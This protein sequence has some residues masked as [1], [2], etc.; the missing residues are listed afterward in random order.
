MKV[1]IVYGAADLMPKQIMSIHQNESEARQAMND[2]Y[3]DE[4]FW[5]EN[6]E[7][8]VL[9]GKLTIDNQIKK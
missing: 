2:Y 5:D 8:W 7:F 4:I 9:S 6:W 3:A 1:W